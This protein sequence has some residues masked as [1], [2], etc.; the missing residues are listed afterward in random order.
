VAVWALSGSTLI[1][2]SNLVKPEL[3]ILHLLFSFSLL[4]TPLQSAKLVKTKV[5]DS[6]VLLIPEDFRPMTN[7]EIAD[8]YFTTKRPMALFTGPNSLVDLGVNQSVTQWQEKDLEIMKSFQKSNIYNL[9]DNIEMISEGIREINGRNNAYFEFVSSVK[10]EE[11]VF[12]KKGAINK[13]T[14]IQ[15]TIVN[16]HSLV[17]N[18]TCPATIKAKWQPTVNEIMNSIAVKKNLQ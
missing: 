9:Y 12:V 10:E 13:Y 5:N 15:Y 16:G 17:F 14:Y 4:F 6:I 2:I 1:L 7:D 8:R 18:F 11:N 3:M